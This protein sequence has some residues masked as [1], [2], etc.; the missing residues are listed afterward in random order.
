MNSISGTKLLIVVLCSLTILA[1]SGETTLSNSAVLALVNNQPIPVRLYDMY[2]RNGQEALGVDPETA[3]GKQ[4]LEKLREGIVIE[5]IERTLIRQDAE[6]RGLQITADQMNAAESRTIDRLGGTEKYDAYLVENQFTR[7]EYRE[8]IKT[9]VYGEL[10]RSE[11]SKGLTVSEEAMR[12]YYESHHKDEALQI[13]ESV[14]AS[15]LLIAA[16]PALVSQQLQ[17][18]KGLSGDSLAAAV[19]DEVE[20]RRQRAAE[21]RRI[22]S[23][24]ADF[25]KLAHEF[26]EDM[27][28]KERG[29]ELGKF[30]LGSHARA[31]DYAAFS[32][33]PGAISEV[34]QT[35]FG[36]HLIKV[37]AHEPA[38]AQTLAEASPAIKHA[39]LNQLLGAKLAAAL[40]DLRSNAKIRINDG[41]RFGELKK[42]PAM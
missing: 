19:R 34:V 31:F 27:A 7:G 5:L 11:L 4:K 29:G 9:E 10:M 42:Y 26:S 14:T 15:H 30:T 24:G 18:E 28:T 38:R 32:L 37:W 3:D 25:A 20:R 16:R 21:L 12:S 17:Q 8:V 36:F 39:L 23:R 13:P 6:R 35:E 41:Y 2:L 1:C 40:N 33:R 22:A